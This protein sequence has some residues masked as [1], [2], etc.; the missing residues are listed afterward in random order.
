MG[1][2]QQL[3]IVLLDNAAH[4]LHTIYCISTSAESP[5]QLF[6]PIIDFL[7]PQRHVKQSGTKDLAGPSWMFFLHSVIIIDISA[8]LG[9]NAGAAVW[10]KRER[11]TGN[12]RAPELGQKC[13]D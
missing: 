7:Y 2:A 6:S 1:V 11:I 4:T 13:H 8:N 9:A 12:K 3:N 10:E 5:S